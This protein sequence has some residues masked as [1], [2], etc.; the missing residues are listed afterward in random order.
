MV[1][2]SNMDWINEKDNLT[3]LLVEEKRTYVEVGKIYGV[4]D[5]TI[6]Q[7]AIKLDIPISKR[8][9]VG[10]YKYCCNCGKLLNYRQFKYCS[11]QCQQ[12][13]ETN[14][15]LIEWLNG[16]NFTTINHL[17]PRFIKNYLLKIH[18]YKCERCGWGEIH[19][20]TGLVPLQVHHKDG[21]CDNN[22][23]DNLELLCPNCHSL[24]D[25]FGSLN[26]NSKRF[27]N[28]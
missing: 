24:T 28:R 2:G 23:I 1:S 15:R 26:E 19:P 25:T 9:H 20:I 5:V 17:I 18:N 6:R 22:L 12:E 7:T 27:F 10:E 21:D 16:K 4:S 3:K 11:N 8:K 13:Y 14:N